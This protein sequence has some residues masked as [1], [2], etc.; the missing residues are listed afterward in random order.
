[1]SRAINTFARHWLWGLLLIYGIFVWLPFLAPVLMETGHTQG[2]HLIYTLYQFFCHQLPQRSY[3]LFGDQ[4]MYDL[5]T[6]Q[7]AFEQTDNP[8][9]LRRF[10]GSAEMGW[11]IAWS[12]RMIS[13]YGGIWLWLLVWLLLPRRPRISFK[14]F[15][16]LGAPMMIDGFT[17][18]ASD[19]LY[20]LDSGFRYNNA[21]LA[22]LT[23]HAFSASFYIGDGVG[24]FNFWLRILT[25]YLFSLGLVWWAAPL[26][27]PRRIYDN[28]SF[29]R[30]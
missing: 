25:G 17:H 7:A 14:T 28:L 30:R 27:A 29:T 13:F 11:K 26:I 15:L 1:M 10:V 6:I 8:L 2:G 9:L 22:T 16:L 24:S 20:S 3:F 18:M 12:D 23:N 5:P 4:L 21:W 19:M